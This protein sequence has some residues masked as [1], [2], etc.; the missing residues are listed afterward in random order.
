VEQ[1]RFGTTT[2][3]A[4]SFDRSSEMGIKDKN[5][6]RRYFDLEEEDDMAIEEV[7]PD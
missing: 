1:A 4:P 2:E 3:R 7:A 5:E 6:K